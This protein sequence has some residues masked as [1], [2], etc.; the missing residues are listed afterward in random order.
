LVVLTGTTERFNYLERS[1]LLAGLRYGIL[2]T[3]ARQRAAAP[4]NRVL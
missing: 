3:L 4:V 2:A 1:E